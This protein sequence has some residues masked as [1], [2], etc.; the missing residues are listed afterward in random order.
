MKNNLK[1]LYTLLGL[2]FL[3]ADCTPDKY[4]MGASIS[5]DELKYSILQNPEDPN[6]I[7]MESLNPGFTPTWATP[8][9]Q[10][11]RVKDTLY[12]A[13]P[14]TYT[15][16]YGVL[17]GGGIVEADAMNITITTTNLSYVDDPLWTALCGGVD[18]EKTWILDTGKY[19]LASGPMGYADPSAT[20]EYENF[21]PNWEPGDVGQTAEDLAA[22]MTFSLKGGPYIT[23]VKPNESGGN[24]SGTYF[25]NASTHTLTTSNASVIR[26]ASFID[27][28]SNWT[29]NIKILRL[30]EN[31][32]R[33]AIMRTNSE[34]PWYYIFNYVSKTYADNYV[35]ED[36]PDPNFNFGDQSEILS[37]TSSKTWVVDTNTPFN[38]S[39][40]NGNLMND[41]NSI[42]DY[43]DW[44]GYN[45][46]AAAN[47][48]GCAITFTKDGK[49]TIRENNG[50]ETEGTYTNKQSTNTITFKDAIPNFP[51]AGWVNISTTAANQWKIV[52][53]EHDVM[54]SVSGIWFGNRDASEPQYMVYH[55]IVGNTGNEVDVNK[56]MKK[57]LCGTASKTFKIDTNWPVDWT[58][59]KGENGWTVAGTQDGWYWDA[60][61]IAS[62]QNASI[63]FTQNTDGSVTFSKTQG[64][65]TTTSP[66]VLD[67]EKMTVTISDTGLP[68]FEGAG[69]WLPVTGPTY[70]WV[71]GTFT[72]V[73]TDG[74]W[75][76]V[77]SG[78]DQYTIYHYILK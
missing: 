8:Y 73:D 44:T 77:V 71:R 3:F 36:V 60:A 17:S 56:A 27:N 72:N 15:F 67:A 59:L 70:K 51:V 49:V 41:W 38:W 53:I 30:N 68:A 20:Q 33:L 12:I 31:Q 55:F 32:M 14:G 45:A 2:V 34:G 5:K 10:S 37:V 63:T 24:E 1:L 46:A 7:I 35:P 25:L 26:V 66:C 50:T 19:G 13:F 54:G 75:L 43:P 58:N 64:G 74:F 16:Q 6:M 9:G 11:I 78:D 22:T 40:L 62:A 76:G 18:N 29:S 21:T 65:I 23:T 39:D 48:A 47:I 28:A 69:S 57:A 42:E 61:T 52:K 4:E